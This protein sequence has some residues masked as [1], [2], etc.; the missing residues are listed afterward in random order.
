RRDLVE[1]LARRAA[2]QV[3]GEDSH[4]GRAPVAAKTH[5]PN[6]ALHRT[7]PR[8]WFPALHRDWGLLVAVPARPVSLC[9]PEAR[10]GRIDRS[11][12]GVSS[13]PDVLWT[14]V[15]LDS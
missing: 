8:D 15:A 10:F 5:R 9:V 2:K 4:P 6:Q 11:I 12:Q 14:L 13:R 7:R 1:Q 3:S